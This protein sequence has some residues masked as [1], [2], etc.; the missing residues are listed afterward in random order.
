VG[1]FMC[2]NS[3]KDVDSN[4]SYTVFTMCT[5][6]SLSIITSQN[7]L[8]SN[9]TPSPRPLSMYNLEFSL[10]SSS[11]FLSVLLFAFC[12]TRVELSTYTLSHSTSP[13]FEIRS[14]KLFAQVSFEP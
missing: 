8:Y 14:H 7:T 5:S 11:F 4:Y 3:G 12:G 10:Q 1:I 13:F 9:A 6:D 2:H